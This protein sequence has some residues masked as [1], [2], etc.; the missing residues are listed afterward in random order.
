[1]IIGPVS[2]GDARYGLRGQ[3]VGE[4]SHPGP[5]ARD[6]RRTQFDSDSDAP[7]VRRRGRFTVLASGSDEDGSFSQIGLVAVEPAPARANSSDWARCAVCVRETEID[8]RKRARLSQATTE[9]AVGDVQD[10][11][12][13]PTQA[14]TFSQL[15]EAGMVP[16]SPFADV[17]ESLER[18]LVGREAQDPQPTQWDSG[19]DFSISRRSGLTGSGTQVVSAMEVDLTHQDSSTDTD[20]VSV[21]SEINGSEH[22]PRN[23]RLT[24]VWNTED[25]PQWHREARSTE[26]LV[27]ELAGRIGCVP[28]DAP[29]PRAVRQQRWSPLNVPLMWGAAG[30]AESVTV[31]DWI[32]LMCQRIREPLTFFESN[33]TA[34][35]AVELG[36]FSLREVFRRWNIREQ[37][38][39]TIWFRREG[40]HGAQ[41]GNHIS[42]RA[43]EHLLNSACREDARVA[44]L[45]SVYVGITLHV[46]REAAA[47]PQRDGGGANQSRLR[48]PL[49]PED[50]WHQLDQFELENV[51]SL[52]VPMLKT[53]PHFLRGRF[54]EC[55][56]V[57]LRERFR[58]KQAGD[59]EAE[60]RA[61]KLFALV[62]MMLLHRPRGAGSI[63]RAELSHRAVDFAN[64]RWNDLIR[65]AV[66]EESRSRPQRIV[67]SEVEEQRRRGKAAQNRVERGQ[68]SRARQELTGASL[69]PRNEDTMQE[70]QRKRPQERRKE[71]PSAVLEFVPDGKLNLSLKMFANC[72][73]GAPSGSSPGPGGCSNEML[74]VCL[75]D[76]LL[77]LHAAEEDFA[78]ADVPPSIFAAF[79]MANMT[80]LQKREGGVRGIATGTLFRRLVA[81]TL[82]RQF[83][84]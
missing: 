20:T 65:Q 51:F 73:R 56:G 74:R 42:A 28:P 68:V 30:N 22:G 66:A 64:G 76:S 46:G 27:R 21:C 14:A 35:E 4:A 3:R 2:S 19:A 31:L 72:L 83:S 69:A 13:L 38:D 49:Q 52:R 24:L 54:R 11:S 37:E 81:R 77:F 57:A 78:R 60:I 80:A 36:W 63:G 41:P 59:V 50:Q 82:A 15:R 53:C 75:D 62:P 17:I 23:R 12:P 67:I 43:Q 7:L 1:M 55:M 70:L 9:R 26:C 61:W 16:Q 8:G 6:M 39:L 79:M 33:L 84:V 58:A 10:Q 45:K 34:T 5:S 47:H 71:I 44:L 40:F 18:D 48:G 29:L 32:T 25:I